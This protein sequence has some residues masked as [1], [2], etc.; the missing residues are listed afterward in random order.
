M[1]CLLAILMAIAWPAWL[2]HSLATLIVSAVLSHGSAPAP[3]PSRRHHDPGTNHHARRRARLALPRSRKPEWV[4][5]EVIRLAIFLRGCR[6]IA[7]AFNAL[8]GQRMTVGHDFV[9]RMLRERSG[10]IA[11]RR[12]SM[13][14]VPVAQAWALDLSLVRT[15]ERPCQVLGIIDR[16]LRLMLRLKVLRHKCTWTLLGHLCLAIA[17][18]G[19]PLRLRTD[20]EAMF[21]SRAWR[22]ALTCLGIR[23]ERTRVASPWQNGCIERFWGTLKPI[24]GRFGLPSPLHL[25]GALDEL[26]LF[27][28]HV[29]PHQGVGGLTPAQAW[30]GVTLTDVR[31][32]AG[33][34]R[35]VQAF[36][37]ELMGYH[38]RC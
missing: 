18:H 10:E 30:R 6:R 24:L 2:R 34:G 25:Q 33:R 4:W 26:A 14:A 12:R 11:L 3:R 7:Q 22:V 36:D 29:R 37:G 15:G 1:Q 17:E 20:N 9:A 13:K 31:R 35:W 32:H 27:Y 5:R 38:L 19:R 16:G 28:N 23:H 21:T 8:H